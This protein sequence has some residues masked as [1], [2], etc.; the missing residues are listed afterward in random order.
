M[1]T[2][3]P[4]GEPVHLQMKTI[5]LDFP[6]CN[7][8]NSDDWVYK[9][10]QYFAHYQIPEYQKLPLISMHLEGKALT[11]FQYFNSSEELLPRISL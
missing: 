4:V 10:N 9:V 11:W 8:E 1:R 5:K 6:V 7:G 3:H 2:P